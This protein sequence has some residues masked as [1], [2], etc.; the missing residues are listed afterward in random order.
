MACLSF[1]ER[2]T[3][4]RCQS[5]EAPSCVYGHA[6]KHYRYFSIQFFQIE[7]TKLSARTRS[8]FTLI[9]HL[10]DGN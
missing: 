3:G 8:M 5:F 2:L 9:F 6:S 1:R 10:S 7:F 4:F